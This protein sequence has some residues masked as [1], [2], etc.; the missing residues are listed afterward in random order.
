MTDHPSAFTAF[1]STLAGI[2]KGSYTSYGK[3]AEVCGVHVRQVQAWLRKLPRD[4]QL[5]WHRIINS[6]RK[7]TEHP[8]AALQHQRLAEEG[9]LPGENGKYPLGKYW[10]DC[11]QQRA[12]RHK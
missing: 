12:N 11:E 10:P 3:L 6:Q 9:V 1:T 4:T 2:P 8:G 5:P 7:I